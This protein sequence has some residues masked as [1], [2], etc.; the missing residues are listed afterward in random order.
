W[1]V[2]WIDPAEA[3]ARRAF[4]LLGRNMGAAAPSG[5]DPAVFTTQK[6]DPAIRRLIQGFGLVLI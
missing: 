2:D 4:S 3:I 1:P 5:P 6:A